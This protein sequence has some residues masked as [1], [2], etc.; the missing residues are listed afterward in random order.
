MEWNVLTSMLLPSF[1]C[2]THSIPFCSSKCKLLGWFMT[3]S[4]SKNCLPSLLT[5]WT[6]W[7]KKSLISSELFEC[8]IICRVHW[9]LQKLHLKTMFNIMGYSRLNGLPCWSI[10]IAC[11]LSRSKITNLS[12]SLLTED[13][14]RTTLPDMSMT[15]RTHL[16]LSYTTSCLECLLVVQW[17]S[18]NRPTCPARVTSM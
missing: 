7:W 5:R 16:L 13:T 17:V 18:T 11:F 12:L 2:T 10:T 1:P 3:G 15:W 4:C 6:L 8:W 14:G 9:I